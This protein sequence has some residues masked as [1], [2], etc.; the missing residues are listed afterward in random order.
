MAVEKDRP[1]QLQNVSRMR[2]LAA[3]LMQGV[4]LT[5]IRYPM[6][7]TRGIASAGCTFAMAKTN[8]SISGFARYYSN[9]LRSDLPTT[10]AF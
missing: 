3:S 8:M 7:G 6:L 9:N 1:T 2:M 5:E 4:V 10:L